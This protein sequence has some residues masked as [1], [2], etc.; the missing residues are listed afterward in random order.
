MNGNFDRIENR[1]EWN[2]L[3]NMQK[4]EKPWTAKEVSKFQK[5]IDYRTLD[6]YSQLLFESE[7]QEIMPGKSTDKE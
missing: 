1:N 5:L 6:L 4:G 3:I 7:I 2:D